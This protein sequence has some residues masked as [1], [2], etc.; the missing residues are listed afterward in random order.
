M[1]SKRFFVA[2]L[3]ALLCLLVVGAAWAE[4]PRNVILLIGDGMGF[5][6]VK[7]ASL[8]A[9]GKEG[10]LAFEPYYRGEVT[11]HSLD[12]YRTRDH[13]TDSAAAATAMATG[14]KTVNGHLCCT[15]DGRELPTALECLARR[16]KWT[17]LVTTVPMTHATPAGFAAH[18]NSRGDYERIAA[19]YF[20]RSRP[21]VLFGAYWKDGKGVTPQKAARAG[22][23]VVK[24]RAEL[25]EF[26]KKAQAAKRGDIRVSGQFAAGQL[27]YAFDDAA[28]QGEPSVT[29][30][31]APHLSEM[32]SAALQVLS[33]GPDG[34]F[35]MVEGGTIDWAC[36]ANHLG[37]TIGE[38]VEFAKAFRVVLDWAK[39]RQ[40]ALIIVTADHECG[41][42]KVRKAAP[43]G[44][45]PE[46]VWTT[47]GH[48]G[49]NVPLYALGPGAERLKGVVDNTDLFR[50]MVGEDPPTGALRS[51]SAVPAEEAAV[52]P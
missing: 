33:G 23:A 38:T 45:L 6:Q 35:L 15:P 7:A 18:S 9:A 30:D 2:A 37:R 52:A 47:G 44:Q 21:N 1:R 39:G 40:D 48:T 13:A 4:T 20:E 12:S 16:G 27:P 29:Y 50:V 34:F 8:Y 31:I 25:A 43:Q 51:E 42:L 19:D 28:R 22:Y 46:V 11:T 32:T 49:A 36:H 14:H 24:T 5:E 41:G 17:G 3:S 26:V 10:A